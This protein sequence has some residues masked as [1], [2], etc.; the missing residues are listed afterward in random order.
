MMKASCCDPIIII[1]TVGGEDIA[2]LRQNSGPGPSTNKAKS[3]LTHVTSGGR[4]LLG[5]TF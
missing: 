4:T 5:N 1:L 2:G 3:L